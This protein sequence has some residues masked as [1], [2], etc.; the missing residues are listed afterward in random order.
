[1]TKYKTQLNPL[2]L[3]RFL[4]ITLILI[5]II[6]C[7][8]KIVVARNKTE[9]EEMIIEYEMFVINN[10]KSCDSE[11]VNEAPKEYYPV[12]DI[13]LDSE[14]QHYLYEVCQEYDINFE[15]ALSVIWLES[16]FDVDCVSL[17]KRNGKVVSKDQGLFQINSLN[18]DFYAE[19]AELNTYDIFDY[20]DN[21]RMGVA[22]LNYYKCRWID[23]ITDTNQL[24]IRF[25]NEYNMGSQGYKNYRNKTG[26]VS[27]AYD[28]KILNYKEAL[29]KQK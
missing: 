14:I 11:L 22:G 25:L 9:Q 6:V 21:I 13:P 2:K 19:L 4:T 24:K 7:L 27:R 23:K 1:M 17:N 18:T 15:L 28:R 16:N 5:I 8:S 20:K 10:I 12:Y 26:K 3:L 29:E